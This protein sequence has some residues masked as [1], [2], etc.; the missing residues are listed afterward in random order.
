MA[1]MLAATVP[2]ASQQVDAD[3]EVDPFA[4]VVGQGAQSGLTVG[5]D[6]ATLG[7]FNG[8]ITLSPSSDNASSNTPLPTVTLNL[9]GQI[10]APL[11]AALGTNPPDGGTLSFPL[12]LVGRS[13]WC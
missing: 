7:T 13:D 2:A 10:V 3:A 5:L 11:L 12:T 1:T 4:G 8:T 6:T 9:S